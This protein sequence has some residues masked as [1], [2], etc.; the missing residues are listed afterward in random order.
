MRDNRILITGG[1]GYIGS[2][3]TNRIDKNKF[4]IVGL[5]TGYYKDCHVSEIKSE[6]RQIFTGNFKQ[7]VMGTGFQKYQ[8][9]P[10]K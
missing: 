5:D 8:S 3:L 10:V 9:N 6:F 7:K 2:V 1:A 4:E